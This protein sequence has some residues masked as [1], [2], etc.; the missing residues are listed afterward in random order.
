MTLILMDDWCGEVIPT[1]FKRNNGSRK[2][3]L[4]TGMEVDS[5]VDPCKEKTVFP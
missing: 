3:R 1:H 5:N 2:R 4:I